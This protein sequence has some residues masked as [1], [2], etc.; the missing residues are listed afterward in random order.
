ML[1]DYEEMQTAA[2]NWI[3]CRLALMSNSQIT[4]WS[5][6]I[7]WHAWTRSPAYRI[8]PSHLQRTTGASKL[9]WP[10]TKQRRLKHV[11]KALS[12]CMMAGQGGMNT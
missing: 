11:E 8:P 1:Q 2:L 12:L 9:P 7:H 6:V 10:A 4:R 5:P 3:D